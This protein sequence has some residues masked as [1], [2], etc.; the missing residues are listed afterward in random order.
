MTNNHQERNARLLEAGGGAVV[1]LEKD[2]TPETLYGIIRELLDD[3][4]RRENMSR[5][6][7]SMVRLDAAEAICGIVEELSRH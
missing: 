7:H 1:L 6:L 5:K 3:R 2:C 4:T